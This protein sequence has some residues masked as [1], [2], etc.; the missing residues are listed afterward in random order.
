MREGVATAADRSQLAQDHRADSM[1]F[2]LAVSFVGAA[3]AFGATAQAMLVLNTDHLVIFG[4]TPPPAVEALLRVLVNLA[5]VAIVGSLSVWWR[6]ID[7]SLIAF[8]T[9]SLTIAAIAAISR[10]ILQ[11]LIGMHRLDELDTAITYAIITFPVALVSII[12]ATIAVSLGR[13]ARN[14][15]RQRQLAAIRASDALAALQEE[16]L[17]VRREVADTLHGTMQQR[18]V[19]ISADLNQVATQLA[20]SGASEQ[21]TELATRVRKVLSELDALR[22]RELRELSAALYP[23]AL[24]RGLVPA[25]RALTSRIPASIAVDFRAES[26]PVPD[27]LDQGSRLLLIRVAEDAVSNALRHGQASKISLTLDIETDAYG[28]RFILTVRNWGTALHESPVL[29]GLDR[30]RRRLVDVNGEL[31]LQ[32][33]PQGACLR[34]WL[35]SSAASVQA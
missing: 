1:L 13:L 26:V 15:E 27:G 2:L 33:E 20:T 5:G 19:L 3:F 32:P 21:S 24:E 12:A 35:P 28:S 30:L 23:E 10:S 31:T 34:A 4:V 9:L 16:E 11:F 22:E 29:S 18:L 25:L 6:L 14:S 17:R 8:L 7:R